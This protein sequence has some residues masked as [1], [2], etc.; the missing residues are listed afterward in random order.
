MENWLQLVGGVYIRA[1]QS[2]Q[3]IIGKGSA[4]KR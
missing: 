4:G 2:Q 1:G 3:A